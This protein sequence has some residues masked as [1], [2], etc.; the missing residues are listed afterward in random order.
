M[1]IMLLATGSVASAVE[2]CLPF[3]E[4]PCASEK[5]AVVSKVE[6]AVLLSPWKVEGV[7]QNG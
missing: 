3:S 1:V 7:S 6:S 4:V 5:E 2:R